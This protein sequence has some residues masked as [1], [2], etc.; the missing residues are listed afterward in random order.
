MQSSFRVIKN[1]NI[2]Q[3]GTRNIETSHADVLKLAT[4]EDKT[5]LTNYENLAISMVE[6]ARRQSEQTISNAYIKAEQIEEEAY[7]KGYDSGEQEGYKNAYDNAYNN[8]YEENV[9]KAQQEAEVIINNAHEIADYA[10]SLLFEAKKEYEN[11][12]IEKEKEVKILVVDIVKAV[13]SKEAVEEDII[14][15]MI[16]NALD[17]IKN[18]RTFIIKCNAIHVKSL[19]T[20]IDNWKAQLPFT[21]EVFVLADESITP[22]NASIEKDNGHIEVGIDIGFN[23]VKEILEEKD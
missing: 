21:C 18:G 9:I 2:N 17:Q 10:D 1:S 14:N 13:L 12:F 4:E 22:G 7:K 8:A 16:I 23:R 5:Y 15:S 6:N 11:Y 19:K 3:S 20:A